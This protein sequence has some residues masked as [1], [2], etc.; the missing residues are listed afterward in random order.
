M[1]LG[2]PD[3]SPRECFAS[4]LRNVT[5]CWPCRRRFAALASLVTLDAK[6]TRCNHHRATLSR[7]D[8]M[9]EEREMTRERGN[10]DVGRLVAMIERGHD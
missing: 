5:P 4:G 9:G 8:P 7:L 10:R 2:G 6:A 1:E 3:R